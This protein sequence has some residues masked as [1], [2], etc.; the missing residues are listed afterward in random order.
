ML[1]DAELVEAVAG[2]LPV[3][4]AIALLAVAYLGS[5]YVVAPVTAATYVLGNG[6][7]LA[8]W[9]PT[10]LAGYGTFM[11]IKSQYSLARP[12]V[13]SPLAPEALPELLLPLHDFGMGFSNSTFPSGHAV[14][15]TV[16]WGLFVIDAPV[17]SRQRRLWVAGSVVATVGLTRV[18]L[19]LHFPGDVLGGVAIGL[20][21]LALAVEVRRQ[22]RDPVLVMVGLATVLAAVAMLGGRTIHGGLV[23]IGLAGFTTIELVRRRGFASSVAS[24]S[25][26]TSLD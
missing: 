18:A 4:A 8:L 21:V 1:Y 14:A 3:S 15:V 17:W 22:T 24:T 16:L 9:P 20:A 5:I 26:G 12:D 10:V 6:D 25:G 7:R 23:V 11:V 2:S 13:E 19:G